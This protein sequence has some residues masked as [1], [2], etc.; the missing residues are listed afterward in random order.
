MLERDTAVGAS[1]IE[2]EVVVIGGGVIGTAAAY[3][4]AKAGKEVVLVE[5]TAPCSG[6]SGGSAGAIS[7]QTK[8]PG[9]IWSWASGVP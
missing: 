5:A 6:A 2:A 4:L 3:Y 1:K 8:K 9:I 7:S